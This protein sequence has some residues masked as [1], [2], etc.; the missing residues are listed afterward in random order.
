MSIDDQIGQLTTQLIAEKA[1]SN[2]RNMLFSYIEELDD[3]IK[4]WRFNQNNVFLDS[5][6][7]K[8]FPIWLTIYAFHKQKL[9]SSEAGRINEMMIQEISNIYRIICGMDIKL[10]NTVIGYEFEEI[11]Q[12]YLKYYKKL[13]PYKAQ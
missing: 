10:S 9:G 6:M 4:N 12:Q 11:S 7:I 3:I 1:I 5:E 13:H 2:Y 8:K